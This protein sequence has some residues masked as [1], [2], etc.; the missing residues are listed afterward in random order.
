MQAQACNVIKKETLA[1]MFSR[2][3]YEILKNTF[4]TVTSGDDVFVNVNLWRNTF[5]NRAIYQFK[6]PCH[7]SQYSDCSLIVSEAVAQRC[8]VKRGVL[9][10][11]TKFTGTH[12]WQSLFF[13]K[14]AG[15]GLKLY[16]KRYSVTGNFL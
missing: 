9:R 10:N 4:F 13:K 14:V 5:F 7:I 6:V 2:K 11:F 16:L 1:Q 15:R 12:L 3:F 8:S